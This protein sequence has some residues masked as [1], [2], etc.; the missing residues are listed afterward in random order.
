VP[1][2]NDANPQ[3]PSEHAWPSA[4]TLQVL[5]LTPHAVAQV[6]TWHWPEASQHPLAH[7]AGEHFGAGH[8]VKTVS[9]D[10]HKDSIRT[11]GRMRMR[12]F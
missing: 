1:P 8:A 2:P 3:T 5:P 4:H 12:L 9:E 7:V 6:P 11:A 10:R